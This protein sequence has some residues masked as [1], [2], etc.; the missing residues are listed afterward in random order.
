MVFSSEIPGIER[1]RALV[2][3]GPFGI[4]LVL[5]FEVVE[6]EAGRVVFAGRPDTRLTNVVGTVHG[7]Y[8]LTVLDGCMGLAAQSTTAP[9]FYCTTLE[10]KANMVRA[11]RDGMSVRAEGKVLFRGRDIVTAEGRITDPDGILLAHGTSTLKIIPAKV[12]ES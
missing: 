4:G 11:I 9:G 12:I 7:G 10:T 2:G 6:A 1:V 3:Q 5:G 8:A